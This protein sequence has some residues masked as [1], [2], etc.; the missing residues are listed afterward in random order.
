M[1]LAHAHGELQA[2]KAIQEHDSPTHKPL[3][4]IMSVQAVAAA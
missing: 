4:V 1:G 2:Q 3:R